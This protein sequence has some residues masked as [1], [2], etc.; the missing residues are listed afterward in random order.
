MCY[1]SCDPHMLLLLTFHLF[2]FQCDFQYPYDQH[3]HFIHFIVCSIFLQ[4]QLPMSKLQQNYLLYVI[5]FIISQWS[6]LLQKLQYQIIQFISF[7]YHI[8]L[9]NLAK[10]HQNLLNH[11]CSQDITQ[12]VITPFASI[13][14]IT[15]H[16][17]LPH[18]SFDS[19]GKQYLIAAYENQKLQSFVMIKIN[20]NLNFQEYDYD[21]DFPINS[22]CSNLL[23]LSQEDCQNNHGQNQK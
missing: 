10:A 17:K 2:N 8:H 22:L 13:Q 16:F 18:S 20:F 12:D 3:F 4:S 14:E 6:Y 15:Y 5:Q 1:Y 21:L 19:Q 23:K 7:N 9:A 11:D